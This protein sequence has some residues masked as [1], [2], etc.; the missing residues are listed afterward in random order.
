MP[1]PLSF[2]YRLSGDALR[3]VC[4]LMSF[5]VLISSIEWLSLLRNFDHR[6]VFSWNVLSLGHSPSFIIPRSC[7]DLLMSPQLY[8]VM[9]TFR[10]AAAF[11]CCLF[12]LASFIPVAVMLASQIL[13]HYRC[14]YGLEGADQMVL[15]VL[16]VLFVD[17]VCRSEAI[18]TLSLIFLAGQS[19]LSYFIAGIAKC[20]GSSWR[21][22]IAVR[23]IFRSRNFGESNVSRLLRSFPVLSVVATYLVLI[24]E[25]TFPLVFFLPFP[26]SLVYLA[27]GCG[28]HVANAWLMGLN[29][30]LWT[31]LATYPAVAHCSYWLSRSIWG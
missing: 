24:F 11:W 30:F 20:F 16:V 19:C 25:C 2:D 7:L 12:P 31:F 10:A 23:D 9:L 26:Y 8:G 14:K 28:F 3:L 4:I 17:S 6:G 29:L 15:I 21:S 27:L 5:S 1:N 22:G 18:S 13:I